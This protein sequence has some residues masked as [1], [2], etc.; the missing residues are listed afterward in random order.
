MAGEWL[1]I[2]GWSFGSAC[3]WFESPDALAS[4]HAAPT[5]RGEDLAVPGVEGE[6]AK[7]RVRGPVVMEITSGII[8]GDVDVSGAETSN[9]RAGLSAN[10][11]AM[12]DAILPP[13]SAPYTR[14]LVH[15]V[16]PVSRS[17]ECVVTAVEGPVAVGVAAFR[18]GLQ[19]R[20]PSGELVTQ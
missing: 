20:V 17:A 2:G 15:H 4:L 18:F 14:T 9:H 19:V 8:V 1:E 6:V 10:W 5:F 12:L 3:C 13:P 7:R 11:A 16:G